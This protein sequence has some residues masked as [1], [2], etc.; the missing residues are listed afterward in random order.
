VSS[1]ADRI[2]GVIR[3]SSGAGSGSVPDGSDLSDEARGAKSEDP[4]LR[5]RDRD[6][7][8]IL[9]GDWRESGG[10]RFLVVDRK[11]APGYRHGRV[12]IAD[13][14]PPE[15]GIWPHL[16][17]L[18]VASID[19]SRLLF[20]DLETTGLAGG[21]GSYA[22]LVGCGWFEPPSPS[23]SAGQAA[24]FRTRQFFLADFGAERA[25]LESVA[26]LAAGTAC[27]VTYNGKT[28]DLPLIET[29]FVLQRM[30]TPFAAMPH[31]DMLHPAR[32]L[33]REED[34]ACRL[35][36]LEGTI[37]GHEREDDVPGFEIPS[38]YFRYV[39]SGDARPLEAVFEHNRLD[40]VSLAML[41]ARATQ[42]LDEGPSAARTAREALGMGRLFERAGMTEEA[43]DAFARAV[44][45]EGTADV[46]ETGLHET[47]LTCPTKLEEQSR[48]TRPCA[49][50]DT[51]AEAL[52][53]Y[54]VVCRRLRRYDEAAGAWRGA[55]ALRHCPPII[56]RE[57][58]E[59]LAVHHEHRARDL[60]VARTF[61]LQ[62]L[63]LQA[64]ASRQ[65]AVRH[66]LAR[67]ERKLGSAGVIRDLPAT[68][69]F[70]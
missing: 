28:F 70:A 7:A 45:M 31:V 26:E 57:A 18:C 10:R 21:A 29:R 2:R 56:V 49:D 68:P 12:A 27:I 20:L 15:S 25:L 47:G 59:A 23:A 43:L 22:F 42:L 54:A 6:A 48:K 14:F 5:C 53:A 39:R 67:L 52:R 32:R 30:Q 4:S 44:N 16:N 36:N 41:T 55:L 66:R 9:G 63:R 33:W 11:Y 34:D 17:L 65:Q 40:I 35:T 8:E 38:R 46:A 13:C 19:G 61:A 62:S 64:T 37:C 50:N 69:L 51:I 3:P 1:L 60:H 58:T 24:C